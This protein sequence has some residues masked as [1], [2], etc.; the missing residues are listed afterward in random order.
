MAFHIRNAETDKLARKLA[1]AKNVGL[2]QA[3]HT[4]LENE[5]ERER[6][7]VSAVERALAFIERHKNDGDPSKGLPADKAFYDSLSGHDD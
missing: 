7:D 6:S 2:T 3:V 1:K 4:A 5:L